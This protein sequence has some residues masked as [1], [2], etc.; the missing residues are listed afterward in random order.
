MTITKS[1]SLTEK[2]HKWIEAYAEIGELTYSSSASQIIETHE[3][4]NPEKRK[5]EALDRLRASAFYLADAWG[6]PQEAILSWTKKAMPK[7]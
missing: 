6:M 3:Q 7:E 1:I 5:Q 4:Q 2:A